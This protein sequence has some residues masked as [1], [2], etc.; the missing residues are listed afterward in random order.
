MIPCRS[1]KID[2]P[3]ATPPKQVQ[4]ISIINYSNEKPRFSKEPM[5]VMESWETSTPAFCMSS[6]RTGDSQQEVHMVMP[7]QIFFVGRLEAAEHVPPA[8]SE[9]R[10]V[11]LAD[12]RSSTMSVPLALGSSAARLT[13]LQ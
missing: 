7:R 8:P 10:T 13:W 6:T 9:A 5:K 12:G 1:M 11:L 4:R 3:D 2:F